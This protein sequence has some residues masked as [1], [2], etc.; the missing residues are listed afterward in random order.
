MTYLYVFLQS[1][2]LEVLPYFLLLPGARG[3]GLA[4]TAAMVTLLNSLT[5]PI[6]FFGLMNLPFTFLTNISLAEGFA[7]GAEAIALT[8]L[9]NQPRGR[10]IFA[11]LIAN[12]VSWQLAPILTYALLGSR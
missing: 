1:N 9:C 7:V 5:H 10:A 11:S 8:L 6:V 2:L 12:L 4:R 3:W